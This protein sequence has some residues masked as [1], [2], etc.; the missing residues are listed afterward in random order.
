MK[1]IAN[2]RKRWKRSISFLL[3][4]SLFIGA[5]SAQKGKLNSANGGVFT[6]KGTLRALIVFVTYKDASAANKRFRNAGNDLK[7][8][9]SA[10]ARSLPDFVDPKTGDCPSYIFNKESD[11]DTYLA[12]VERNFSKTFYLMSQGKFKLIGEVFKDAKGRPTVV[13]IDPSKGYSWNQMN[14]RAVQKMREMNPDFD[15]S[16]F[17]QRKN[18]PNFTFDNSDTSRHKNDKIID[19]VVFVHRYSKRWSEQPTNGMKAWVG[20]GGGFA[21]TGV[22][23]TNTING[24]RFREGFTM[25]YGSGVFVHEVAHVLFNA[26]H[27]MGVNNVVGNFFY[28][29]SAGWG[30]MAPISIF[31]GFNAWERWYCGFIEP[32]ADIQSAEDLKAG[33]RFVL[34]DFFTTGD[35]LRIAIPFSGGQH[36]WLENHAKIHPQ[37]EHPWKGSEVGHGDV[38]AG[39][40]KG[41]Y[42]YVESIAGSRNEIFSALSN[43][44][45][46]IKVLH[47]G[48]NFDYHLYEELPDIKNAWGNPMKSFRREA[49]NPISGLNNLYRF[50]FD[51]NKDGKIYIDQNYNSSRTEWMA[52][53]FREEILVDSFVNLYG[54]FG[55]YDEE[56]AEGYIGPVAFRTGDYLDMGSNPMPLNY[57]RYNMQQK[58]LEPYYLNGLGV[59][60]SSVEGNPN[61]VA[62]EVRYDRTA[63]CQNRRWTGRIVLPNITKNDEADL[64]V[65]PCVRL[66]INKSG[67]NNRHLVTE[68]GDFIN[69]TTFTIAKDAKMIIK[70]KSKVIL[71]DDSKLIIE[72]GGQLIL[73]PKAQLVIRDDAM[74][75]SDGESIIVKKGA[76]IVE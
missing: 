53:I 34:Q 56:K 36:L 75:V 49:E 65:G 47:A 44:A 35:A 17:D 9:K 15:F 22:R 74:V 39:T 67:T 72:E 26:P 2:I 21:G 31:G 41:V 32:K 55:V 76:K 7:N 71:E 4:F 12:E 46:G 57:P 52:P 43:R 54:S 20:S 68:A 42:A 3:L 1:K 73:E 23:H 66:I 38:V 48:G 30:I 45:N 33:N 16:R 70:S 25:T 14:G 37:D 40:A 62:V 29:M 11:F 24:Y 64:E 50:P 28:L 27:I 6:P 63:L 18:A 10:N 8:W 60:F 69:P 58:Q 59:K 61:A 51:T 13:E 5:P 19:F